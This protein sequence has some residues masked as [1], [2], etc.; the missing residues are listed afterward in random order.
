MVTK[1]VELHNL[2]EAMNLFGQ[3]DKNLKYLEKQYKVQ[4]FAR[5][6]IVSIR[7]SSNRVEK[8]VKAIEDLRNSLHNKSC[9]S[10]WNIN[11]IEGNESSVRDPNL[12]NEDIIY[13]TYRGKPICPKSKQQKNYVETIKRCDL[14]V[15]IGPAGTG[16]TYLA[17]ATAIDLLEKEK[18]ERIII[19][20]PLVETGEKLGFL[21]GDFYEKVNP[22]LRPLYDAFYAMLGPEKFQQFKDEEIIEIVPLAYMRGRTLDNA[23]IIL[24]E[25][26]NTTP[27]QMKMF[28][29]RLGFNSQ[30]VIT[31]DVTQIDL[32]NKRLS[33][34]VHMQEIIKNVEG[35]EFI[36]FSEE[37]V[38]RH[39][40]VR[41]II[42]AYEEWEQ[43][44]LMVNS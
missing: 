28:L 39:E 15:G 18:V 22:Y 43:K 33:G 10:V 37:D 36:Y 32:V 5:S 19:T 9:S 41:K 6:N 1:R 34:L 27:E 3:Y 23:F 21:P 26:Q 11:Q 30:T 40:L 29:T 13:V 12:L 31:G 16:K 2:E 17:A 7:G 24:D 25:A 38:I 42:H 35:I 4:I 8:A 20:R 44:R 14:V